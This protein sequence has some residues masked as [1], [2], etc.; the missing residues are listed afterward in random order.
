MP[1]LSELMS[2]IRGGV[3]GLTAG[4]S[5]YPAAG[6]MLFL[7]QI[8]QDVRAGRLT[9]RQAL[10]ELELQKKYDI[11]ENPKA[12]RL[13]NVIGGI[14]LT[15]ATGTPA[16]FLPLVGTTAL[17]GGIQGYTEKEDL[18]DAA[19][20]AATGAVSG[21][22]IRGAQGAVST[23]ADR[24]ARSAIAGKI[25]KLI[26]S[27]KEG[28]KTLIDIFKN[29]GL[30]DRQFKQSLKDEGTTLAKEAGYLKDT[31]LNK[32]I[33][34]NNID[35]LTNTVRD[36]YFKPTVQSTV[37]N[38]IDA[39]K[40][41]AMGSLGAVGLNEVI[42]MISN[43]GRPV[44]PVTAALGGAGLAA[45]SEIAKTGANV[46]TRMAITNATKDAATKLPGRIAM[47]TTPSLTTTVQQLAQ[48]QPRVQ[49]SATSYESAPWE[50]SE[51]TTSSSYWSPP[52]QVNTIMK[53]TDTVYEPAPWETAAPDTE[54]AATAGPAKKS[55]KIIYEAAPWEK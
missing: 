24:V 16:G 45:R 39:G 55:K 10:K 30:T 51:P 32:S 33:P 52:N 5:K 43:Q 28:Q 12:T 20:G 36:T 8:N 17:Q 29:P 23:V 47:A 2:G 9:W 6:A 18:G 19:M 50:Q 35:S 4:L 15:A 38:V 53:G 44:D 26:K 41:G 42:G 27:G 22:V 21:G 37:S 34:L 54:P 48:P 3:T 49:D 7:D 11:E 46:L 1:T 25:D 40:Q 13:G 31:V 14:G